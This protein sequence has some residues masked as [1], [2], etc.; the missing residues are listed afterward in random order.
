MISST[1]RSRSSERRTS[2]SI[3]LACVVT[4]SAVVGSSAISS[5]GFERAPSRSS[6]A[7]ACRRRTRADTARARVAPGSGRRP[8]RAARSRARA[9]RPR[10]ARRAGGAPRRSWKPIVFTGFSE[11][12]ASWKII[13]DPAA[14]HVAQRRSSDAPASSSSPSRI[15]PAV[16]CPGGSS[17][18]STASA[19]RRLAR[20]RLADEREPLAASELE[21]QIVDRADDAAVDRVLDLQ[22]LDPEDG[23]RRPSPTETASLAGAAISA[24]TRTG[25]DAARARAAARRLHRA[26]AALDRV[27]DAGA[28]QQVAEETITMQAPG[29]TPYHQS[30]KR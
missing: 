21:R 7:G 2:R 5:S 20:A 16:T 19:T 17:R 15:D 8:R 11:P 29:I 14:A 24:T 30:W 27:L 4:S 22:P 1:A 28:D 26:A 25:G 12:S 10:S 18:P 9:P 3:T 6:R 23:S 13:D